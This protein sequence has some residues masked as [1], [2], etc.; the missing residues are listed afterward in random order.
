MS[1]RTC[2]YFELDLGAWFGLRQFERGETSG[3]I[4]GADPGKFMQHDKVAKVVADL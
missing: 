2:P 1:C 3:L 4:A